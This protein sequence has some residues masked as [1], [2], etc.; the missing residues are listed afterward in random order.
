MILSIKKK[1]S[2]PAGLLLRQQ[3]FKIRCQDRLPRHPDL[4][5]NLLDRCGRVIVLVLRYHFDL[6]K[7]AQSLDRIERDRGCP[8]LER[9][10]PLVHF[11][12]LS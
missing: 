4:F 11:Q 7:S 1:E 10:P 5:C 8:E 3:H 2:V 9:L 6:G 12:G